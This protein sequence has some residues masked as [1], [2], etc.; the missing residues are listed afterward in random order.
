MK[1]FK[2]IGALISILCI[3]IILSSCSLFKENSI[4]IYAPDGTPALALADVM[5]FG[6]ESGLT[7]TSI[8]LVNPEDISSVIARDDFNV[9]IMPTV[10]G[11]KLYDKGAK[12]KIVSTHVFGSLYIVGTRNTTS[13]NDL[14]G[15]VL[16]IT[17]GTT[18]TMIEYILSNNS[19]EFENGT[20]PVAGKVVLDDTIAPN[21][22]LIAAAQNNTEAYGVLGEPAVSTIISKTNNKAMICIDIQNEYKNITG[23]DSYPQ[24][25]LFIS[26]SFA[27]KNT[28]YIEKL[29]NILDNNLYYIDHFYDNL[30]NVFDK[31]QSNLKGISIEAIERSNLGCKKAYDIKDEINSYIESQASISLPDKFYYQFK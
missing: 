17:I 7:K 12:I 10:T 16:N 14:V 23:Y 1:L 30:D 28:A 19:I 20:S 24:A 29:Y 15:K 22:K 4:K 18:R 3:A 11:A 26:E 5:D 27:K 13:L 31:Y 9:A 8:E 6:L 2:R 25:S 21:A